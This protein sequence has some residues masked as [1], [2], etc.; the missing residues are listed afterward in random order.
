MIENGIK[1]DTI[2]S[3]P[4]KQLAVRTEKCLQQQRAEIT[5]VVITQ[6]EVLNGRMNEECTMNEMGKAGIPPNEE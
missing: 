5:Q 3:S 2:R 6:N 1:C 4:T